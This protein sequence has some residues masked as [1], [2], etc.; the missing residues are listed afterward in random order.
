M[1]GKTIFCSPNL[2][3]E[4]EIALHQLQRHIEKYPQIEQMAK[5]NV[6]LIDDSNEYCSEIDKAALD[7]EVS[8]RGKRTIN[9]LDRYWDNVFG[10]STTEQ[11]YGTLPNEY[12]LPDYFQEIKEN[13][14]GIVTL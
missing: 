1:V 3:E 12:F 13:K 6:E 4:V 2:T 14:L 9:C 11:S 8:N 10:T 7:V 5:N